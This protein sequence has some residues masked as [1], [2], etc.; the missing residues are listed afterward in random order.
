MKP[1]T[2]TGHAAAVARGAANSLVRV[3]RLRY[4]GAG[5]GCGYHLGVREIVV[6]GE[7]RL[8]ITDHSTGVRGP[9]PRAITPIRGCQV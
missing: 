5:A 3:L 1:D 8:G 2:G 9:K 6:S 7:H 4:D